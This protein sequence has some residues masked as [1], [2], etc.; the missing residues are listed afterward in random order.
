MHGLVKAVGCVAAGRCEL[1]QFTNPGLPRRLMPEDHRSV[2]HK[3]P[4]TPL[5]HSTASS[6]YICKM[7]CARKTRTDKRRGYK[8]GAFSGSA[9]QR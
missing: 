4:N 6:Q 3:M 2:D 5:Q 8:Q 7:H 9:V 1:Q